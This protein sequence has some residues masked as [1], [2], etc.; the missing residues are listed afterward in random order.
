MKLSDEQLR[1]A[2]AASQRRSS[3]DRLACPAP[4]ALLAVVERSGH[5]SVRLET[6]DHAMGCDR[7]RRELDLI[8]AGGVAAGLPKPRTWLRSPSVGLMALAAS[9]LAV[10]GVRLFMTNGDAESGPRLRGG[11]GIVTHPTAAAPGGM[12]LAWRPAAGAMS[13]RLEVLQAGRAVLDTTMRDTSFVVSDSLARGS[14]DV[15]WTVSAILDDGT[16]VSSLPAQLRS[17]SR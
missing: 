1:L 3:A 4:E 2:Y 17:P 12:R 8:R 10:A 15:V 6:L 14:A 7:C 13:Y 9:L 16:T 11:A 5:E